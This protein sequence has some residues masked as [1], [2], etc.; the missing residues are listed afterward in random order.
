MPKLPG[1]SLRI[2]LVVA[3]VLVAVIP[4]LLLALIKPV[5]WVALIIVLFFSALAGFFLS[6]YILRPIQQLIKAAEQFSRGDLNATMNVST[7]DELEELASGFNQMAAQ[8]K[9]FITT[10]K[11]EREVLQGERNKLSVVVSGITDGVIAVDLSRNIILFNTAAEKLTGYK[12]AE[13]LGKPIDSL[14]KFYEQGSE[15]LPSYYCPVIN[16]NA[17]GPIVSKQSLTVVGKK[18]GF[19]NLVSGQIKEGETPL[20]CILTLHDISQ[21][22]EFERMKLDFVSMAAHELRTPLTSVRGYLSLLQEEV[23]LDPEHK[24]FLDRSM[25]A[26][27][28]LNDLVENLL[29]VAK[30]ERGALQVSKQPLDWMA[31]LKTLIEELNQ[32][33][34]DK[35][36]NLTLIPPTQ[37]IPLIH[38]DKLRANEVVNNLVNNAINYTD[39]G[40]SVKVWVEAKDHMVIT[41]VSDTGK[42]IPEEAL[43][44]LFTKFFRIATVLGMG[45]KGTGLGL[46]ISKSIVEMHGGKIWVNSKLGQGSTFSFSLPT[47][48]V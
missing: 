34:K 36:V 8:L 35:K 45:S 9:L 43:P 23:K 32:R 44:H 24:Q 46:Y 29:S 26:T 18:K 40:G 3:F 14:I 31:N 38:V 15:L 37:T 16:L 21:E 7:H 20:G 6:G 19:A 48:P 25:I 5:V 2:K 27:V 30:I 28:Q 1:I 22:K 39:S 12:E 47:S 13:I 41:H 11:Q 33:A 17:Q 42:G 4:L 10:L